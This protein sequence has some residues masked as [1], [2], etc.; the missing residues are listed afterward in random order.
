MFTGLVQRMGRVEIPSQRTDGARVAIRHDAWEDPLVE[1]ESVAVS[2]VCL[3]ATNPEPD[4]FYCDLLEETIDRAGGRI[5]RAGASINLER[6]M[7]AED[8][9]G[10]HI[11]QGHVDGTGVISAVGEAGADLVLCITAGPD[12]MRGLITKGSVACDGVSLT[13]AS[14]G[15]E[16]FDVHIIPHSRE[17]TTLGEATI[18]EE[19]N[20]EIDLVGKYIYRYLDGQSTRGGIT[21]EDLRSAGFGSL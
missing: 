21:A 15:E 18:G 10:G 13:V 16:S 2:G 20:I 4:V 5:S 8:R 14:L 9:F 1:G 12:L 19:I 6:A 3:T 17:Q 7:R 11:V